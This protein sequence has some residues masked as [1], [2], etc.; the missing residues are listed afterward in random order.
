M[1]SI[2]FMILFSIPVYGESFYMKEEQSVTKNSEED[3][4]YTNVLG[5]DEGVRIVR[6]KGNEKIVKIPTKIDGKPVI[7][8]EDYAFMGNTQ[9]EQIQVRNGSFLKEIGDNAFL[10]CTNLKS[11]DFRASQLQRIGDNAF[12][13]CQSLIKAQF[14]N[15]LKSIGKRAFYE[16]T[17]LHTIQFGTGLVSIGQMAFYQCKSLKEV[18]LPDG[19][20]KLYSE[21]STGIYGDVFSECTALETVNIGTGMTLLPSNSFYG[22]T[23]LRE[24]YLPDTVEEIGS[25][26]FS[27]CTNLKTIPFPM[28]LKKINAGAFYQ[29]QSLTSIVFPNSL[30]VLESNEYNEN[31]TFGNCVQ[32]EEVVFGT[33]MEKIGPYAFANCV[34]L[35]EV[36]LPDKIVFL[37]PGLFKNCS[38]LEKIY[39]LGDVPMIMMDALFGCHNDLKLYCLK[40][41]KKT[42]SEYPILEYEESDLFY[43]VSILQEKNGMLADTFL[44]RKNGHMSLPSLLK[45]KGYTFVK[46]MDAVY[47]TEWDFSKIATQNIVLYPEWKTN[48]YTIFFDTCG[49]EL[50]GSQKKV[51]SYK[52]M[53]GE[54]PVPKKKEYR[55]VGWYTKENGKGKKYQATSKMP[56]N[57]MTLYAKWK[58][59]PEKP[60]SVSLSGEAISPTQ[61]KLLWDRVEES[62]G[63]EIY[64]A[65]TKNGTFKKIATASEKAKGYVNINLTKGKTYYYKVRT[66]RFYHDKKIYGKDS[67]TIKVVLTGAPS[68]TQLSVKK[69]G[70]T[71]VDL[72]WGRVPEADG[73][74]VYYKTKKEE[75]MRAFASFDSRI[76]G[77]YHTELKK[78]RTYYYSVRAFTIVKGKKV[79]GQMSEVKRIS[80]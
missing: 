69:K 3:F 10:E 28:Q 63:Y 33:K 62:A 17:A 80:L 15:T 12:S 67:N 41:K 18:T 14:P 16:D 7:G 71:S 23:S 72:S 77:C 22:C 13:N 74:I 20:Q 34:S 43:R 79:Y 68:K 73:Y 59:S 66:Y 29:C 27:F 36:V 70:K 48:N 6:Y 46:W 58:V 19:F 42:E 56:A 24:V 75:K 21:D 53:L 57:N 30:E 55:F 11:V 5:V 4:E 31:N 65:T 49:G 54:L 76:L 35:K 44:V 60:D 8:I 1:M 47:G 78:G 38:S 9:I 51:V 40:D 64:R 39:C 37:Y 32:L 50:Q 45:K 52:K 25:K 61:I 2:C 26:A